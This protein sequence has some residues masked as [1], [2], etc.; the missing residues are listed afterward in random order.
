MIC[1]KDRAYCSQECGNTD[2]NR[3]VTDEVAK[4]AKIWSEPFGANT[5]IICRVD[6]KTDTCGY[7]KKEK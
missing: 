2:C 6:L 4:D 1:Y 3:N 5:V 7:I